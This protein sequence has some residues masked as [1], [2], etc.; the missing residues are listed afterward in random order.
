MLVHRHRCG[1]EKTQIINRLVLNVIVKG[2]RPLS[3]VEDEAFRELLAYLEPGYTLPGR[4]HFTGALQTKYNE[5]CMKLSSLLSEIDYISIT[6]D[7]WTS[8]ATESYLTVT[9]HYVSKEWILKSHV[10]GTLLLEERHTGE[11][12]SEWIVKMLSNFGVNPSKIVAVVH[13]N[14]SN[15]V[16]AM[17]I[18][19]STYGIQSFRCSAHTLQL[20]VHSTLSKNAEVQSTL[21]SARKLVEHFRR[22]SVANTSLI[23]QQEQMNLKP[24]DLIQDVPTR[25]SSTFNMCKRLVDLRL[26]VSM[27]MVNQTVIEKQKRHQ[28]ELSSEQWAVLD[29]TCELLEPFA[30]LTKYLEAE[31]YLSISA[32]QPLVKGVIGSLS[33]HA[34]D[35][36]Y[37]VRFKETAVDELLRRFESMFSP[38]PSDLSAIPVALRASAL[39][40][41]F[42]KLKSLAG[43]QARDIRV[44]IENEL[45]AYGNETAAASAPGVND[46]NSS[47]R[48]TTDGEDVSVS[49]VV[50]SLLRYL[51]E[52]N[53]SDDEGD[54]ATEGNVFTPRSVRRQMAMFVSESQQSHDV[55]TLQWWKANEARFKGLSHAARKYLG[56]PAT[57]APS[58]RVFSL[59]GSICSRRRACLSPDNLDALV[60]LNANSELM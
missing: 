18:L 53:H 34:G 48:Q 25:W 50:G 28:L 54:V 57:S 49:S 45:V 6:T 29:T 37:A 59:A 16:S 30:V 15:M 10:L 56:I 20:V 51:H 39:D 11:H 42:H 58:E 14:A 5:V 32:V 22:S 9:V 47:N 21:A 52:D 31:S 1:T 44:C 7:T 3:L 8:I 36:D 12:L 41:R 23:Q 17:N 27:V 26:P 2:Q 13:D 24:L 38:L 33:V 35:S 40:I 19:H 43:R 46:A 55:N 60:F 4:K